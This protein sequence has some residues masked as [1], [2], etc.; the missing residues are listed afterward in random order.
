MGLCYLGDVF[1]RV[2]V[3]DLVEGEDGGESFGDESVY[4][5][6]DGGGRPVFERLF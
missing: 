2:G 3:V 1:V 4:D 5:R 6:G